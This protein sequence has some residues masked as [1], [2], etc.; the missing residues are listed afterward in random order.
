MHHDKDQINEKLI[1][2]NLYMA[3]NGAW[4]KTAKIPPDKSTTGG[5]EDLADHIEKTLMHDFGE[6]IAGNLAPTDPYLKEF[7][8]YYKIASN[9]AKR[10]HDGFA[11]AQKF[12]DEVLNLK[13]WQDWQNKAVKLT[14]QGYEA[15]FELY[16]GSDMKNTDV[17]ALYASV[18]SLILPDKTYYEGGE[19]YQNGQTLLKIFSQMMMKL[20]KMA[21]YDE[22]FARVNIEQALEFD[23]SLAPHEKD[24]TELSNYPKMYNKYSFTDFKKFSSFLDLE[25]YTTQLIHHI[26]DKVIVEEPKYYGALDQI[27][28]EKTFVN[29]KS[30][31]LVNTLDDL[32]GYLSNDFRLVGG[33][34]G[35]ALSGSKEPMKP[36]KAAYYLATGRFSQTVGLYYAHK[37]FGTKAKNDVEQ[38]VHKMIS[39]YKQR[40]NI[41]KWLCK[42]TRQ[43]AIT[44]LDA[45]TV[46][47][48]YPQKLDPLCKKFKVDENASLLA[49][50]QNFT[51]IVLA[52]HYSRWGKTVDRT[53]WQMAA[54]TVNAYYSPQFNMIVF[55]AAILQAPFYGLNQSKSANYGGIGAVIAHEISHAFDNNGAQFDEKGNLNNWWTKD[56]LKH[57]QA[58][59]QKMITEFNGLET[60]V[61]KV[62]G[63]LEVSEN[64]ADAGGL[65]CALEAAKGENDPDL[66]AF[67]INWARIWRIKQTTQRMKLLLNIDVHA[68]AI[69]RANIQ[70]QNLS[71]FYT[72]FD[73]QVG[74]GMYLAPNKRV[75]IW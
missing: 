51:E 35:R 15:P 19:N 10:D 49:N 72:T 21:G 63:K 26:P 7:V 58:L 48:G 45:L 4:L 46:N 32:T 30:W 31:L 2:D 44:K 73:I 56:D 22:E 11:P 40:L 52:D 16:V 50:A 75:N 28:N 61:G 33:E 37:Y 42:A 47:V 70:P 69:L 20:F 68:P 59:A 5:F 27:I 8:K 12:I 74:D 25:S 18:P 29:F 65:S 1:K 14:M 6:M 17:Y 38:M 36:Q 41:K 67:F 60:E 54:H 57:F 39:V 23:R 53:R 55:P 34:Y 24:S 64:I 66:K 3:V 43:E 62:N 71:D 13:D 9:F